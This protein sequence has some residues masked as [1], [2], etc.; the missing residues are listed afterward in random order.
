[1]AIWDAMGRILSFWLHIRNLCINLVQMIYRSSWLVEV[2]GIK[3]T[4][5]RPHE[6]PRMKYWFSD[7]RFRIPVKIWSRWYINQHDWWEV[8]FPRT[9][10]KNTQIWLYMMSQS[11]ILN[12]WLQIQNL[13]EN[14]VRMIYRST[15]LVE[16]NFPRNRAKTHRYDYIWCHRWNFEF[17]TSDPES[18]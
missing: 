16:V 3:L 17:L 15:W 4:Q 7:F 8:H 12:F 9:G 13:C 1:M 5:I 14:T 11:G 2:S 6:M 10:A 18:L